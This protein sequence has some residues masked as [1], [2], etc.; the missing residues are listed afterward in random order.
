[1][2]VVIIGNGITGVTAARR[3]RQLKPDWRI[4]MVSAESE[5]FFSRPALMYLYM[6]HMGI[7]ETQPFTAQSFDRLRIDRI[8][9]RVTGVDTA[10]AQ[11]VCQDREALPYDKL[12]LATG[13]QPNKF[14][15]PGQDLV[16]V[17]GFY[18]LQDLESLE[19]NSAGLRRAVIVGGG[20][21]YACV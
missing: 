13:S 15:W 8:R 7:K 10:K 2:Q 3:L 18:S 1:M 11:L 4:Q 17:S 9:A 14:G 12:L 6:G 21:I 16:G 20:F 5:L 19:A